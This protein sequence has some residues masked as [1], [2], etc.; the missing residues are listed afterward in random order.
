[1]AFF[2]CLQPYDQDDQQSAEKKKIVK[3]NKMRL[4]KA[5]Q[6]ASP[7]KGPQLSE[8]VNNYHYIILKSPKIKPKNK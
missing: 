5:I 7:Y 4:A 2:P 1:M 6:R 8:R 3:S